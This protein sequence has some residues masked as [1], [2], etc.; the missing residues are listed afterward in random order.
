VTARRWGLNQRL[1][2]QEFTALYDEL[3]QAETTR[4]RIVD[5]F[6]AAEGSPS[7]DDPIWE[8]W[9]KADE[10]AGHAREAVRS[11]LAADEHSRSPQL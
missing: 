3:S 5:R 1:H 4:Q 11:F 9:D 8:E 6:R 10:M 2:D 7:L